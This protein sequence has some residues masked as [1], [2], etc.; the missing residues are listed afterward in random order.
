MTKITTWKQAVDYTFLT[1]E[2]WISGGGREAAL[3][4]T[5]HFTRLRGASF[6]VEKIRQAVMAIVVAELKEE[7][8]SHATINRI[9]SAVSTVLKHCEFDE[10]ITDVAKFRRFDESEGR[11]F[12]YTKDEVRRME[13]VSRTI[14]LRDDM[15]DLIMFAAYTGMR[16]SEILRLRKKDVDLVA[17]IIHVGGVPGQV[18]KPKN[19]RALPIHTNIADIVSERCSQ[20]S[21][22]DI[23]IFG[24][25]WRNRDQVMGVFEKVRD[26]IPKDRNDVF[27]T[28][29]HSNA[30]WLAEA[31]VPIRTIMT[32]LGHKRVET[33]LRYA[34][35]SEPA[36]KAAVA[37]I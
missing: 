16:Q 21:R 22:S 15:A 1:R 8:K 6:P 4:N 25:E 19:Y 20:S 30:T 12:W 33:T 37:A 28:L 24:D 29:R 27:H 14:F 2:K 9:I 31:G 35:T 11:P 23:R 10:L 7:G 13:Q 34:K 17:D 3:I 5:G 18:T 36:A 26:L 32:L